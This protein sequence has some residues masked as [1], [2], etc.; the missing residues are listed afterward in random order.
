MSSYFDPK[1]EVAMDDIKK[2]TGSL[3]DLK[4]EVAIDRM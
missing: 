3:V 4:E 2:Y 1:K